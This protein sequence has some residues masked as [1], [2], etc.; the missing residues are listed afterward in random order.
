M[1]KPIGYKVGGVT[2][3]PQEPSFGSLVGSTRLATSEGMRSA[4]LLKDDMA[5]VKSTEDRLIR[6]T[7]NYKKLRT[8]DPPKTL[9]E[10]TE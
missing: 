8:N 6:P 7:T 5:L 1:K 4:P 3:F 2:H 9:V 10:V